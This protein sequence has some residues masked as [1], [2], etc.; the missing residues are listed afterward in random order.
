M[1]AQTIIIQI[2]VSAEMLAFFIYKKF[3]E[4]IF[5]VNLEVFKNEEF[6]E[7]RMVLINNE[8]YFVDKYVALILGYTNS[9][10]ALIDHIQEDKIR[11]DSFTI[12][13]IQGI[14]INGSGL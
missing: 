3:S 10:K 5:M 4:G 9:Q 13:R 14:L 6:G 1:N 12:N 8:P 7:L 11:N 2:E